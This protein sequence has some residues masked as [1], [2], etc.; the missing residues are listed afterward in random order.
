[1]V[2]LAFSIMPPS[3][4]LLKNELIYVLFNFSVLKIDTYNI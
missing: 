1:M 3:F 2:R 4:C